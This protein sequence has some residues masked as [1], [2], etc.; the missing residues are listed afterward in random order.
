M[1]GKIFLLLV[2]LFTIGFSIVVANNL[3]FN[4]KGVFFLNNGWSGD[5]WTSFT[6]WY[7]GKVDYNTGSAQIH[8]DGTLSGSFWM[9]NVGWVTFSHGMTGSAYEPRINCPTTIWNDATQPCPISGSAWSQNAGWIVFSS[10]SI[11]TGSWAY[12]DP[13]TGNFAGWWWSRD[14]GWV[15]FWSGLSGSIVPDGTTVPT[16]PLNGVPINFVS[17]IAIVG[18]IAGSR[19]FSVENNSLVNQDVGYSYT[20]INHARLLD[21]IRKNIAIMSRNISDTDLVDIN[22]PHNFIIQKD[23]TDFPIDGWWSVLSINGKRTVV[24]IGWDIILDMPIINALD[25]SDKNIAL[26][27]LKDSAGNGGNIIITDKV[28]R[29]YAYMYAEGTVY[30]GIKWANID[31][32]TDGGIWNIP[33]WQLFIRWLVASKNTIWWS[34]Q[35]PNPICPVLVTGICDAVSS[36]AYDWDYFRTYDTTDLTQNSLPSERATVP[37]L[38]NATMIIEYDPDIL[39][40]PPPWFQES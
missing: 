24:V 39:V 18:N 38:Q 5:G 13:N 25:W 4:L 16:D 23:G 29:I 33:K 32:Y 35:K 26:I 21:L 7:P 36:Y 27:A 30:S 31:P 19:V 9:W 15:P 20:T 3:P 34:Q 2:L 6:G 40:D 1:K 11:W 8:P 28:K 10:T 22:S 14:L 12:F 37:K 17:R